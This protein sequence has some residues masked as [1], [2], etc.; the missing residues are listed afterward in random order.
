MCS[1]QVR[2]VGYFTEN[3]SVIR[4]D[5]TPL[6]TN[7]WAGGFLLEP[8]RCNMYWSSAGASVV[9]NKLA[10]KKP[11]FGQRTWPTN[12]KWLSHEILIQKDGCVGKQKRA[13]KLR[14][15]GLEIRC[16]EGIMCSAFAGHTDGQKLSLCSNSNKPWNTCNMGFCG[17][18]VQWIISYKSKQKG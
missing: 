11:E 13:A 10:C 2:V 3:T 18:V 6:Y 1:C 8:E 12:L 17:F 14:G 16:D 9:K 5:S 15:R 4:V 7:T